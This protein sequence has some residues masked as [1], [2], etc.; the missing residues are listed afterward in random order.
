MDSSSSIG[1][2]D[3]G[4]GGISV[5]KTLK[6]ILPNESYIYYGDSLN[7][8]YGT[9]SKEEILERCVS[10]CDF[11]MEKKVK[12]IVIA[13]NTATSACVPYLRQKYPVDIVGMEPALKVACDRGINQKVSVWATDL[14]LK[15][16]K[17]A[18][19]M[20]RFEFDH[21]I[22]KVPCPKLVACVEQGRLNDLDYVD[23][24]LKE[25][26]SYTDGKYLDSIV[27]GCTH[28]VF[29]KDRLK[30]LVGKDVSIIDGNTGTANHVKDLLEQKK[31]LSMNKESVIEWHNS[32]DEKIEQSKQLFFGG[33]L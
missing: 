26:L 29:F 12:M 23:S 21:T 9:K 32:L 31:L 15:E 14:T 10:I 17:F 24:L 33:I 18:K 11:F 22:Y 6:E 5:L 25:Y 8:P 13:C 3:S 16:E 20:H 28:F 19:L 1:V 4:L 27:L 30:T 2:F 7:N